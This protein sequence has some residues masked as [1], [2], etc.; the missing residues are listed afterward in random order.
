MLG[1]WP[2]PR[3]G[4][5]LGDEQ[6]HLPLPEEVRM[7]ECELAWSLCAMGWGTALFFW[8]GLKDA[9]SMLK[10]ERLYSD[11]LKRKAKP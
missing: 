7:N 10:V 9:E 1:L 4:V 8:S 2:L 3:L 6:G 5:G 11:V